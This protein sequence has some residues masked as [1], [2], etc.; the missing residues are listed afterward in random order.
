[1]KK[2]NDR[3]FSLRYNEDVDSFAGTYQD[4]IIERW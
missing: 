3:K 4:E 2:E 1:M